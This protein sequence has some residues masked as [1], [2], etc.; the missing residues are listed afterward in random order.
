[1]IIQVILFLLMNSN[2]KL[3]NSLLMVQILNSLIKKKMNT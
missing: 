2:I 3:K 1:M